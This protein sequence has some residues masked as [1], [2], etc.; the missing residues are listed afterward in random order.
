MDIK[1]VFKL[2]MLVSMETMTTIP[3]E[4]PRQED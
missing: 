1:A 2:T 4:K 3:E